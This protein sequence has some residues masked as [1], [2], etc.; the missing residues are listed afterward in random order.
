MVRH[1]ASEPLNDEEQRLLAGFAGAIEPVPV[2]LMYRLS[3]LVVA[4][5]MVLLP[6]VYLGL[7][8]GVAWLWLLHATNDVDLLAG[9]HGRSAGKGALLLYLGPLVIGAILIVFMLKPIFARAPRRA[10]P[11]SIDPRREPLLAAFV[12][13]L[14]AA[15]G[16]P[17]PK[18][19]DVECAVN[20]SASFRRGW[21]SFFGRDLVLTIGLPLVAGQ[22]LRQ[23]SG[24]L[25]HEFGHFAQGAGMR[26]YYVI[27]TVNG[28]FARVVYQRDAL[29]QKLEEW[30]SSDIHWGINIVLQ[31]ARL[32]VWATRQVLKVLMLVGHLFS[33]LLSRQMEFD[34]DR[35]AARLTG[36]E[37]F[38]SALRELPVLAAAERGAH[39]DLGQAW[40]ER[41]L[42]DDLPALVRANLG[43]IPDDLRKR[44][45]ADGLAG[46]AGM[47]A[48]H[49]ATA[50]RIA[51]GSAEPER[52]V[53]SGDGPATRLFRDFPG[54]CRRATIAWYQDEAGL[55]VQ[56][57]N[58][59]ATGSLVAK[60]EEE[61]LAAR[62]AEGVFGPLWRDGTLF[63]EGPA[64][65]PSPDTAALAREAE[66]IDERIRVLRTADALLAAG[67]RI[68][69]NDADIPAPTRAAAQAALNAA[70]EVRRGVRERLGGAAASTVPRLRVEA[71]TR[72]ALGALFALAG[73]QADYDEL[74]ERHH[75]LDA[76]WAQL[77]SQRENQAFA[78]FLLKELGEQRLLLL[79][80]AKALVAAPYPFEHATAGIGIGGYLVPHPPAA[81]QH[82]AIMAAAA[83]AIRHLAALHARSLARLVS[84]PSTAHPP[85]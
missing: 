23:F 26:A 22:N 75:V 61:Q 16:A 74:R 82:G 83:T 51:S 7:I 84:A 21:L 18:R 41:R 72:P 53:F 17:V 69:A 29:D 70:R 62:A 28:W 6:L 9:H 2:S 54:I 49:P 14:C 33:S 73:H 13:R 47:Y 35:H 42:A 56:A 12:A 40:R 46:S 59:V 79:R 32:F 58:L 19:I 78:A 38:A 80:L 27:A 85:H 24:V 44:L 77:D 15:V 76:L 57:A 50:D 67:L 66:A 37:A 8:G 30:A 11:Q 36:R 5:L 43:Q 52:G 65:V 68:D 81:D 48:S 55:P 20:A 1:P 60:A 64:A 4:A 39:Q 45:I 34:A 10:E 63:A 3:L 25:A 31:L 71:A